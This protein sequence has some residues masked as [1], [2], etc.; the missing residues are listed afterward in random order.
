MAK[1][2]RDLANGIVLEEA[3][4]I[5]YKIIDPDV[6]VQEEVR[7]TNWDKLENL[8][9]I[10]IPA[11]FDE[12]AEVSRINNAIRS[13][14][15]YDAAVLELAKRVNGLLLTDDSSLIKV[16]KEHSVQVEGI[17]WLLDEMVTHNCIS[18]SAAIIALERINQNRHAIS[19]VDMVR[20]KERWAS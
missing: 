1:G 2:C 15:F 7:P 18:G 6:L 8:G 9:L 10:F 12:L 19:E 11:S 13:I 5:P 20:W 4:Q 14:S 3:F 16:A 17:I